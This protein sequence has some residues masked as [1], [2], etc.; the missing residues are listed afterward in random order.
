MLRVNEIFDSIQGEGY[1]LGTPCTFIRLSGCNLSCPFC[2]TVHETYEHI[3]I[4]DIVERVKYKRFIVVTGGEPCIH[5]V[6][7]AKLCSKLKR[8]DRIVALETN[9]TLP[10]PT[11]F[12]WITVSPK[13][14]AAYKLHTKVAD[15]LKF[16]VNTDFKLKDIKSL[17]KDFG[18]PIWLQP[19]S[20]NMKENWKHCYEIAM[21]NPQFRVGVQLHKLMGVD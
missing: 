10:I 11:A 3:S 16:V 21:S 19:D 20:N 9:G 4:D 2:D 5:D 15:E 13:L 17:V 18:G 14:E 12:D 6:E 7:L 8:K 1:W